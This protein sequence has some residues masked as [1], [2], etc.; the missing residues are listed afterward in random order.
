[1][2]IWWKFDDAEEKYGVNKKPAYQLFTYL[3]EHLEAPENCSES[4]MRG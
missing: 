3:T 2:P 1:M 4:V